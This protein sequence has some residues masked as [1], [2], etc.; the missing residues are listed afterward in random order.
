MK[1][2]AIKLVLTLGMV[3]VILWQVDPSTILNRFIMLSPVTMLT[4]LLMAVVQIL[5]LSYRWMLVTHVTQLR[6]PFSELLRCTFASQFFS[7]GLPA[8]VGGDALRIWWVSRIGAPVLLATQNVL[9]DRLSGLFAL[10][11]VNL[12]SLPVVFALIGGSSLIVSIMVTV[13]MAF[14][15]ILVSA[16]RFGRR[17]TIVV[18]SIVQRVTGREDWGRGPMHWLLGLQRAAGKLFLF[19]QGSVVMFWG[20]LIHLATIGLCVVIANGA[21]I[22]LTPLGALAVVPGVLLLSYLPISVGGWGVREGGMA[23]ALGLVGVPPSDAVFVGLALGAVGLI[24][25]LLGA[26]V[27]LVSPMPITLMGRQR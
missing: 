1:S 25:A 24:A 26:L 27:W 14:A 15:A 18:F 6:I 13:A 12:V 5:M 10:L 16:S 8:S 7:Q 9:L 20:L 4:C 17:L 3:A 2:F 23:L 11:M 19:R 21:G 22:P